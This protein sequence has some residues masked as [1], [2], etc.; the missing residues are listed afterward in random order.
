M[1]LYKTR[2]Y[3]VDCWLEKLDEDYYPDSYILERHGYTYI[4]DDIVFNI[5][6][7]KDY[8]GFTELDELRTNIKSELRDETL[9]QILE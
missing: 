3:D 5:D 7:N 4:G 6:Y 9:K 1:R 2:Y 8:V